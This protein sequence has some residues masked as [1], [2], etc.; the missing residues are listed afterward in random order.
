MPPQR[1]LL[2]N[3]CSLQGLHASSGSTN[4][5][6]SL[7]QSTH[8]AERRNPGSVSASRLHRART[9]ETT[10][11]RREDGVMT[12]CGVPKKMLDRRMGE[13]DVPRNA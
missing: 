10:W 8:D 2:L 4:A 13:Q 12:Q 7:A 11:T 9:K 3:T 1:E 5:A 6:G